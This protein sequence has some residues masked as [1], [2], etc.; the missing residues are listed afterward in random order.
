ML[1]I[2]LNRRSLTLSAAL[3]LAGIKGVSAAAQESREYTFA[4]LGLDPDTG[5]GLQESYA[6]MLS[7]VDLDKQTVRTISIPRVLFVEIPE[8]GYAE[9]SYAYQ[10][11]QDLDPESEWQSGADMAVNTLTHNFGVTCDGVVVVDIEEMA[12]V[13]DAVGGIEIDNPYAF[14]D[15]GFDYPVGTITLNGEEAINFLRAQSHDGDGDQAMRRNLVQTA[16]LETLQQPD[17]IQAIP[18]LLQN[19]SNILHTDIS[20]AIQLQLF[21]AI[22]TISQE[23]IAFTTINELLWRDYTAEGVPILQG[24]WSTLPQY[25]QSWLDGEID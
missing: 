9:I 19:F 10:H 7:R 17:I 20:A 3:A 4:L 24:D 25:V 16:A 2:R 22:P 5:D 6:I 11:G 8:F 13:I 15:G 18:D 12:D 21:A 1:D 23:D 14:S